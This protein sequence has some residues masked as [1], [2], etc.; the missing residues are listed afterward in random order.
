MT[1][2]RASL[3]WLYLLLSIV[4]TARIAAGADGGMGDGHVRST[5]HAL[6]R[7]FDRGETG[8]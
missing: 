4:T 7:L 6:M 1:S 3:I 2:G 8:S 5:D